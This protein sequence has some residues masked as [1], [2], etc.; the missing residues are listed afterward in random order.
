[1]EAQLQL[2]QRMAKSTSGLFS[3]GVGYNLNDY[4]AD[5]TIY[6]FMSGVKKVGIL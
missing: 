6:D 5:G 4:A 2:A 3:Y 1:M